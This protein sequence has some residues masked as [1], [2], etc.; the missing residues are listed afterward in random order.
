MCVCVCVCEAYLELYIL[1]LILYV[2]ALNV[3]TT[4]LACL[5][6]GTVMHGIS[7]SRILSIF[8]IFMIQV[9]LYCINSSISYIY[10]CIFIPVLSSFSFCFS[11]YAYSFF[12]IEL[13]FFVVD[14]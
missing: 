13:Y 5:F 14:A 6:Q 12:L 4:G 9:I 2:L 3:A 7:T 8:F 1:H 11:V 10:F